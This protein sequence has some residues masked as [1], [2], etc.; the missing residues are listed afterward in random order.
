MTPQY[1]ETRLAELTQFRAQFIREADHQLGVFD[2]AIAE[3]ETLLAAQK[4][5]AQQAAQE[6]QEPA[7]HATI[8][9]APQD[10]TPPQE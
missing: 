10:A 9:L 1:L 5:A 8:P 6:P 4:Q 3:I 2:G 7:T